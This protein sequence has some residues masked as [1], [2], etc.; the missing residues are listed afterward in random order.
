MVVEGSA[1]HS[2]DEGWHRQQGSHYVGNKQRMR[3]MVTLGCLS[4]SP[5]ILPADS[6]TCTQSRSLILVTHLINAFL[7]C[8]EVSLINPL[9]QLFSTFLMVPPFSFIQ[10][11]M[12]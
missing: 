2:K 12:W 7:S 1:Y 10:F 6:A 3:W 5:I 4:L 8:P 9:G 11:L